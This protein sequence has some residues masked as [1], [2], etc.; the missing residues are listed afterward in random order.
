MGRLVARTRG[1]GPGAASLDP[2]LAVEGDTPGDRCG[3]AFI[4]YP[5]DKLETLPP[6][7]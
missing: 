6:G 7:R 1:W 4:A 3:C 5:E 2:V